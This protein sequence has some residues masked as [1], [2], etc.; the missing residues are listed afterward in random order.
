MKITDIIKGDLRKWI[1]HYTTRQGKGTAYEG[2]PFIL[3]TLAEKTQEGISFVKITW[4]ESVNLFYIAYLSKDY[5]QLDSDSGQEE[6]EIV[7]SLQH[8]TRK[9]LR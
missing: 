7:I 5:K 4:L 8:H 2:N 3:L 9:Y 1:I 6:K